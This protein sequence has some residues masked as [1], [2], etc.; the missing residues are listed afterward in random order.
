MKFIWVTRGRTW[1][2]R[3]LTDG[4]F[5]DPLPIYERAFSSVGVEAEVCRRDGDDVLLRFD[6][7]EGRRDRAGRVIV[8]EFVVLGPLDEAIESVDD[9]LR[10]VWRAPAVSERYEKIWD[11]TEPPAQGAS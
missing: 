1:G 3:F 11:A 9:G 6:D 5:A 10:L 7:P 4:G 2:F 8:H